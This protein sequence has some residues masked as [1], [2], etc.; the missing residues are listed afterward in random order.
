[1]PSRWAFEGMVVP[2]AEAR[3]RIRLPHPG[4]SHP[5]SHTEAPPRRRVPV[6]LTAGGQRRFI[7]PG[8]QRIADALESAAAKAEQEMRKAQ[9]DAERK[10]AAMKREMEAEA[11]RKTAEMRRQME[12]KMQESQREFER[13]SAEMNAAIQEKVTGQIK[14]QME[15]ANKSVEDKLRGIQDGMEAERKKMND[16]LEKLGAAGD[17]AVVP[18]AAPRADGE[19]DMAE[20][21][22][23]RK[24]WRAPPLVPLGVLAGMVVAGIVAT[25]VMLRRRD[26]TGR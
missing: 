23:A 17:R 10:A 16:T 22:F 20:R 21:F 11:E 7:L 8:R 12:A 6:V 25:G 24:S 18:A 1:M 2:E 9:A 13:K 19:I 4:A 5:E 3:P 26:V 15:E 14:A